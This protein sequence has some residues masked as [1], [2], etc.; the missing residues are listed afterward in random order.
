MDKLSLKQQVE[1]MQESE[2]LVGPSG[3]MWTN[4]IFCSPDTRCLCWMDHFISQ[5]C[6]F[7][8]LAHLAQVD[9]FYLFYGSGIRSTSEAYRADYSIDLKELEL[10]LTNMME[11]PSEF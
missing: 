2:F 11:Q 7:S 9:L 1:L 4:L 3:A 8:N 5:F 6:C 10:A